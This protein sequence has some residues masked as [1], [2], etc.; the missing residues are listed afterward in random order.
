M[1]TFIHDAYIPDAQV[2]Y[3][4]G[5]VNISLVELRSPEEIKSKATPN[6][7]YAHQENCLQLIKSM[8]LSRRLLL[9]NCCS[10]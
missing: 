7:Q 10:L 2:T 3:R 9:G 5:S 6:S 8:N 4:L 1:E